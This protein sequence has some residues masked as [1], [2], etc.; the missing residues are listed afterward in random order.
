MREYWPQIRLWLFGLGSLLLLVLG[1]VS[2]ASPGGVTCGGETMRPGDRC[3]SSGQ[4]RGMTEQ[5]SE[6]TGRDW[7]FVVAG[8]LG[9]L[10][11]GAYGVL[12][13][14]RRV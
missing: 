11:F 13:L 8:G 6:N 4:S 3:V 1:I 5:A 10:G 14:R 7:I 2:L 9:T 12:A